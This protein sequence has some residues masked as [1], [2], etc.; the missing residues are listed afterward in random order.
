MYTGNYIDYFGSP[1]PFIFSFFPWSYVC[2]QKNLTIFSNIFE[3]VF[4]RG[5][6]EHKMYVPSPTTKGIAIFSP[7]FLGHNYFIVM[8]D[9]KK[10]TP[11]ILSI[12][13]QDLF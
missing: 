4:Q 3:Y 5:H 12:L 13:S 6:K 10:T 7:Q 11:I 8:S 2:V 1:S 9:R